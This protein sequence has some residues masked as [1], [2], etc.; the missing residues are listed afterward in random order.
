M[1]TE[2]RFVTKNGLDNNNNS[3]TNLGT[4]GSSLALSGAFAGTFTFTGT[5]GVTF[6]TSGTLATTTQLGSYVLKAGDTMS[7][8]LIISSA[9]STDILRVTNTGT[10]NSFVVEDST[11]PDSSP[12]VITADGNVGIGTS[13]GVTTVGTSSF[14]MAGTTYSTSIAQ[15]NRFSADSDGVYL[16][17]SK[18]R[19]T[20]VNTYDAVTL[21]DVLGRINFRGA[22]GTT[23]IGAATI[24]GIVDG[25]VTT[26]G[27][28]GRLV[29]STT[30]AGSATSSERLRINSA[31]AFGIAGANFGTSGQVLVSGGSAAAPAWA[32]SFTGTATN[33]TNVAITNDVATATSVYPVWSNGTSGNQP[34]EVSDTKLS[35]VPSTG[36]LSSTIFTAGTRF[37][38]PTTDTVG[39]PGFTWATDTDTGIYRV[40]A[41]TLGIAAGGSQSAAF[42]SNGMYVP[43]TIG[44]GI[45][46]L[47][48]NSIRAQITNQANGGSQGISNDLFLSTATLT[49]DRN[50]YAIWNTVETQLQN[51]TAFGMNMWG[52]YNL[53]TTS[54]TGGNS[55][56]V[57]N[58]YGAQNQ[59]HNVS[60]DATF[61]NVATMVGAYNYSLL[62][63]TSATATTAFGSDNAV[64]ITGAGTVTTAYGVRARVQ[65]NNASA[66]ITNGYLFYGD[67]AVAGTFTNRYGIYIEPAFYNFLQG[68]VQI[69][70]TAQTAG[71]TG[72]P[73]L[74]VGVSPSGTAGTIVTSDNITSGSTVTATTQFVAPA[75]DSAAAPGYSWSGDANMGIFRAAADTIAF[76]TAGTERMRVNASGQL[77]IGGSSAG[78]SL[79]DRVYITQTTSSATGVTSVYNQFNVAA[80][81]GSGTYT[82]QNTLVVPTSA[83]AG[84]GAIIGTNSG[85]TTQT[86]GTISSVRGF[87]SGFTSSAA[88]ATTNL[89]LYY[90]AGATM[91]L[92][93]ATSQY[94]YFA[95]SAI[96]A[97]TNNYGFYGNIAAAA[98]RWNLFMNGTANNAMQGSLSIGKVTAP[99]VA[100]D[101]AGA[102]SFTGSLGYG[103]GAGGTV[104]Q[105]TSKS[106]GVTLNKVSGQITM[107]AAALASYAAASF[108]LTNSTIAATDVVMVNIASGATAGAYTVTVDAVAAGSCRISVFNATV[109]SLSQAL[110]LNFVVFKG[111]NA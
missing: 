77:G 21:G 90:A 59:A 71:T 7:G 78:G 33:A 65:V 25:T 111:V 104:T 57:G 15:I 52:A 106:T 14:M 105:A 6:P 75:A 41:N 39:A 86:T 82:G 69:G 13:T 16:S 73:G 30:P 12:F 99:A 31:G 2:K 110:V 107:N 18:S 1:S 56:A 103:T 36:N 81:S 60:G 49:S 94:G 10:G 42:Y 87:S 19:G 93:T 20:S 53:S 70:G 55:T 85:I 9:G 27:M 35:F 23:S 63:G 108:T 11:N 40:L 61:K 44:V 3:I 34:L 101:V 43:G 66:T 29:F 80:T 62:S 102:G 95:D 98:G 48:I 46:P 54:A 89:Y 37:A 92:G 58:M 97:A 72:I 28:P 24:V 88:G 83:F 17:L 100:L 76:S 67:S 26:S 74:G 51:S 84:T 109:G 68:G 79:G 32:S 38:A 22:D 45:T 96:T 4:A 64:N 5:T 91:T 50:H 47:T 8:P